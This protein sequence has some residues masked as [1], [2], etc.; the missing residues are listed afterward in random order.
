MSADTPITLFAMP[1]PFVGHIGIIQRNAISSWTRLKPRPEIFLFGE[2]EGVAEIAVELNV[3]HLR[4]IGRN[5]F[6]TPLLSALL[7]QARQLAT[8]TL[9]CY[10]NSDII[11]LQ[12]FLRAV[13]T[14]NSEFERFL[15]VA[16]RMNVDIKEV[17]DFATDGEQNLRCE[18]SAHGS[19]GDHTSIDVFVFPRDLYVD[20]PPFAIGRAWFDQWL[21]KQ[22][23]G[24]GV[25]VVDLTKVARAIHQNHAYAHIEGG[26]KATT[27]GEEARRSL[28]LY[29]GKPHA[30]TML[31]ATHELSSSGK[32]RPVHFRREKHQVQQWL[33]QNLIL[34]T[35]AVRAR[36]GFRRRGSA[37]ADSSARS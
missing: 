15:G 4:D 1:K 34:R 24:L 9:I 11:L 13:G 7:G 14:T 12:E 20:V 36:L 18:M 17:L 32:I 29:G 27:S 31:S 19:P 35:A 3:H 28:A 21:I 2:E 6:G 33:W 23:I 22:A 5:E 8:T 16:H 30:F 10:A 26:Y 37:S 25:P